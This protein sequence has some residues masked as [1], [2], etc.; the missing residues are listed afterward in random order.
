[1]LI[2]QHIGCCSPIAQHTQT[3]L[4]DRKLGWCRMEREREQAMREC[5]CAAVMDRDQ[6]ADFKW[7][8]GDGFD[9]PI[10]R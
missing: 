5:V 9:Q 1:M 10:L 3:S 6:I 7:R 4:L 2:P 8:N